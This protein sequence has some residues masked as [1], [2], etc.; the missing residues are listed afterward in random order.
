MEE[1]SDD[2]GGITKTKQLFRRIIEKLGQ[3]KNIDGYSK[4]SYKEV[5]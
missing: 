2:K 4:R 3:S 5:V 1:E